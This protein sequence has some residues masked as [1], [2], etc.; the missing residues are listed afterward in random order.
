MCKP[1]VLSFIIIR[2][3]ISYIQADA[4]YPICIHFIQMRNIMCMFFLQ[5]ISLPNNH[6]DAYYPIV[7]VCT[8][9]FRPYRNHLN[10]GSSPEHIIMVVTLF[11]IISPEKMKFLSWHH[12]FIVF[13]FWGTNSIFI[14]TQTKD[15]FWGWLPPFL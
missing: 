7:V 6:F 9:A 5:R 8:T 12:S 2:S 14:W 15:S 13:S 4:L 11:S 3:V 10:Q 1:P